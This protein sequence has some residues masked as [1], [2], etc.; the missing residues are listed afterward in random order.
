MMLSS[1]CLDK[2]SIVGSFLDLPRSTSDRRIAA[3]AGIREQVEPTH[4]GVAS[5]TA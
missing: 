4:K 5:P 2:T 1:R 3:Q